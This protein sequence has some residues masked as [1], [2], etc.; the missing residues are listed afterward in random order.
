MENLGPFPAGPGEEKAFSGPRR[1]GRM[2]VVDQVAGM[3]AVVLAGGRS[4]RFGR[5]KTRL[6]LAGRTLV[7][8]AVE[9]AREAG[10]PVRVLGRDR[11]PGLGP[12]GGVET[13]LW[14]RG[15]GR[16]LFLAADMPFADAAVL[17]ALLRFWPAGERAVFAESDSGAGFPFGLERRVRPRVTRRLD[18]GQR[19]LQGLAEALDAVRWVWPA[20]QAWGAWNVNRPEDWDLARRRA[21]GQIFPADG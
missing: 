21:D 18:A 8:R 4:R 19:S 5:D 9:A 16:V 12:L 17:R 10:L 11:R 3:E 1:P 2:T 6:R 14:G 15:P 13:A 7:E 20:G